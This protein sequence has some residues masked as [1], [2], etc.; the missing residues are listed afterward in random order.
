MGESWD[1]DRRTLDEFVNELRELGVFKEVQ[2]ICS[3]HGV[4]RVPALRSSSRLKHIAR[5][6]HEAML[7]IWRRF[8][9]SYPAVGRLFGRDH[10]TVMAACRKAEALEVDHPAEEKETT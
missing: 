5:A 1:A 8:K 9:W 7:F 4:V 6:R 2:E 10:T 3:K